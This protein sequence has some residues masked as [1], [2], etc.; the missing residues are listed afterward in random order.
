MAPNEAVTLS[1][2]DQMQSADEYRRLIIAYQN[3]AP[4]RLGDVATVRTGAE[5]SWLGA[6]ALAPAAPISC[7]GGRHSPNAAGTESLPKSVS[8]G[9]VRSH[10][11]IRAPCAMPVE[12]MLATI[13]AG[14]H[15]YPL[16]Y[17]IFLPQLFP[18]SPAPLSLIGTFAVMVH[19]GYFPLIT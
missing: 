10:R 16:F 2:N 18:A 3:G 8:H 15:D 13:C 17:V 4:R 9:P 6:A 11:N 12:L 19:F 7:D 5:N 1:A 14:R